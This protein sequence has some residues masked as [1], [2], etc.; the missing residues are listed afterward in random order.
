MPKVMLDKNAFKAL[1]SE[2]RIDILKTLDG[3][4]MGLKDISNAS[5]IKKA[6]IHEHL[7]K[8]HEVGLVKRNETKGHKCV[9][10]KLSWKG[11]SLL[12]PDNNKIVIMFSITFITLFFGIIGLFNFIMDKLETSDGSNMVFKTV[13]EAEDAFNQTGG[14]I[15]GIGQ[16]QIFMYITIVCLILFSILLII[17]ISKYKK[18][19]IQKL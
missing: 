2:T 15:L 17:S 14:E 1:A 8:L 18:N 11:E 9:Y 6:T 4:K 13:S 3:K 10:Y 12:H 16:N 5:N 7:T 19:M